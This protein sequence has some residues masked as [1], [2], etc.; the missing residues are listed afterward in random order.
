MFSPRS[1]TVFQPIT[2]DND[3]LRKNGLFEKS[4]RTSLMT[5]SSERIES[6]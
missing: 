6:D 3:R 2:W 4:S 1:W 5:S